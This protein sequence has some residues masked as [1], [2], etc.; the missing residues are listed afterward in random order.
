MNKKNRLTVGLGA[1]AIALLLSACAAKPP[2]DVT[3]KGSVHAVDSINPDSLGRPSPLLSDSADATLGADLL[4]VESFLL[5][6]GDTKPYEGEFD[7]QTRF[8]GVIAGYRDI[9]QAQWRAVVE[10]PEKSLLKLGKRG[11]IR[12]KADSLAISVTVE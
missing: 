7:P 3:I 5:A 10:M 1:I 2:E 12:I 11:G 9:H 4:G 6:P 8:I